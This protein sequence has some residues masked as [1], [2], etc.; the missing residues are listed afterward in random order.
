M[1]LKSSTT[2]LRYPGGKQRQL[3]FFASFLPPRPQIMR[4]VEPFVGGGAVFF[5]LQPPQSILSDINQ[6]L[7]DLYEGVKLHPKE[8]WATFQKFP[9]SKETYY[10]T[11]DMSVCNLDLPT[12]AARLLY[13]NRTC[14]K[15]MW[16]HNSSGS[17][18]VGYGGEERRW[19]ITEDDLSEVSGHLQNSLLLRSDFETIIETCEDGDFL[20]LDPPY[21]PGRKEMFHAHYRFGS[22]DFGEQM[23]LCQALDRASQRQV[24]WLMTNSAHKDITS[25]YSSYEVAPLAKGTGAK[26]GQLVSNSDEVLIRNY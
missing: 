17:F 6:E 1:S 19:V 24:R 5:F 21:C 2:F 3:S 25:L 14:F 4:Y 10:R 22:F 9:A 20:F 8:V 18:N 26:I 16:R 7:I 12:R 23:R 11:R 13:L 15:G